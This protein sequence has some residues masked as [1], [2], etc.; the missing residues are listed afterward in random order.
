M[1][2]DDASGREDF[3]TKLRKQIGEAA[4][5]RLAVHFGGQNVYVPTVKRLKPDHRFVQVL[6]DTAAAELCRHWG[7]NYLNVPNTARI[8]AQ[9]LRMA[10]SGK[11]T[12][13]IGLKLQR[14]PR[15]VKAIL[16]ELRAE[17]YVLPSAAQRRAKPVPAARAGRRKPVQL[18]LLFDT[19]KTVARE[20]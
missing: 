12:A 10:R 7:G 9:A 5:L 15:H 17:G 11:S 14:T 8:H 3:L 18:D 2:N 1:R 4:A 13:E 6:G 19:N 16:A 20:K